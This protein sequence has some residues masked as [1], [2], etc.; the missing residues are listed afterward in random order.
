MSEDS[1][2][3]IECGLHSEYELAIMHGQTL[4]LRWQ[5]ADGV[6]KSQAVKP[7]DLNVRKGEEFLLVR[8]L[9]GSSDD[10]ELSI[11]LDRILGFEVIR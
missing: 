5:D 9:N 3:P 8:L 11:R 7:L 6:E 1:Y 10:A 2:Q 4:N